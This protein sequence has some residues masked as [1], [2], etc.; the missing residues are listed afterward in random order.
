M[1]EIAGLA[2]HLAAERYQSVRPED[3]RVGPLPGYRQCFPGGVAD[4]QLADGE[5]PGR[6]F[7]NRR[8]NDF[9]FV[10]SLFK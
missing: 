2:D 10:T 9:E 6:D 8:L 4:R 7:G 1:R 3:N 5:R